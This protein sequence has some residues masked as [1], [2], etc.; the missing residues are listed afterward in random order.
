MSQLLIADNTIRQILKWGGIALLIIVIIF[1]LIVFLMP[2]KVLKSI[3]EKVKNYFN[4]HK[5]FG[6]ILRFLIVGVIATLVDMFVMGVVMYF[7]EPDIYPSFLNVFVNTPNPST[8]ATIVGTAVGFAV[9]VIVNYI[10]SIIFV[11]NEKGNSK[12]A[13]GFLTF[14]VLSVIGLVINM[15]GMYLGYDVIGWNQWLVKII[16]VV[17]V[18]IYNYIS[19]R[20]I[21][22]RNKKIINENAKNNNINEGENL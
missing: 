14:L 18:L 22:F 17:L 19:K 7:M 16:M 20:L 10:L 5:T 8:L 21:L 6:E 11:F 1:A 15:G 3:V 12:T 2:R 9:G 13:T 4:L